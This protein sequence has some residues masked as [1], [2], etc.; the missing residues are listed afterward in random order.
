[1]FLWDVFLCSLGAYGGPEAHYS[2]MID[3][4]AVKKKYVTEEEILELMSITTVLPGP[5][6]TQTIAAIGYK[7]GGIKLSLMTLIVWALP[8]LI[9][10]T[11][12][13]FMYNLFEVLNI[14][15][16]AI[17]FVPVMALAFILVASYRMVK[18]IVI[19]YW[20]LILVLGSI[21]FSLL[22]NS[23]WKFPMA[24]LIG[25][26]ANIFY[27]NVPFH[28]P[29]Q[30]KK[31]NYQFLIW[32]AII[33]LGLIGLTLLTDNRLVELFERFYRYGYLV[34]GGGQVVIPMM[35][36]ELVTM[37]HYMTSDEFF[38]GFGIVQGLPGPMFSFAAYAGGLAMRGFPTL[39]QIFGGLMSGM[40]IFL[41]GVLLIWFVYPIWQQIREINVIQT[42]IGGMTPVATGF[43][44]TAAI[45]L[46]MEIHWSVP[47]VSICALVAVLLLSKKVPAPFI[48]L[49]VLVIGF[50][51]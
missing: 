19:N 44:I 4:L 26:M 23:S 15:Q 30:T 35:Q 42:A 13:S 49:A 12:L 22:F 43:V 2:V 38:T 3:Q 37:Q 10:M 41:P 39:M 47:H 24:L 32:F 33:A 16:D 6:S 8:V 36:D 40:A 27:E 48:V 21:G 28:F 25:S 9:V 18:K 29:K 7:L 45:K 11:A 14:S 1:M 20:K 46:M 34:I 31:I 51:M 5:G 50:L 17:K